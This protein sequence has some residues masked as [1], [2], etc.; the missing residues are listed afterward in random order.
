MFT[1]RPGPAALECAMDVWGRAEP[2]SAIAP[3]PVPQPPI[4]DDAV[5]RGREASRRGEEPDD[6][7][8]RRRAGCVRKR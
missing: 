6:R 1:G 2:V 7:L 8:R 4:D 5:T 3:L